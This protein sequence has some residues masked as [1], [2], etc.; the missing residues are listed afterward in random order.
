MAVNMYKR[1]RET[2]VKQKASPRS[3]EPDVHKAHVTPGPAAG[4]W[5]PAGIASHWSASD[6]LKQT[7]QTPPSRQGLVSFGFLSLRNLSHF[8]FSSC[9][10]K[11]VAE[12]YVCSECVWMCVCVH[13]HAHAHTCGTQRLTSGVLIHQSPLCLLRQGLTLNP[14]LAY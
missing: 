4:T 12:E 8:H 9:A 7:L 2:G 5:G 6:L 3:G 13:T 1:C 10:C 11:H 14:E